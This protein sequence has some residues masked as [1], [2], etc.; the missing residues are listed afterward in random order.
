MFIE[1]D[2][3]ILKPLATTDLDAQQAIWSQEPVYR[4]ITGKPMD[5][6]TE[7]GRAHV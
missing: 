4:Y 2:R 3:L 6:E 5:R 7:I 1:T